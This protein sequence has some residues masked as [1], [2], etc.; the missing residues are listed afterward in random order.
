M[1]KTL[2]YISLGLAL[3]LVVGVLVGSKLVMQKLNNQPVSLSELPSPMAD[4]PECAKLV[5]S[6][7]GELA[8]HR[9][10]ELLDP[11][12]AGAAV[13]QSASDERVTLRCGVEAPLQYTEL[14][15]TIETGGARWIEITDPAAGADLS[16]W[17]TVD[18]SPVVAVTADHKAVQEGGSPVDKL[19]LSALPEDALEP[20]PAPL[21]ALEPA[22]G[23]TSVCEPLLSAL[24]D[25]LIPGYSRLDL[26]HVVSLDD[27]SAA[28]WG[29]D[30]VEPIVIRCGLAAPASYE[31]GAQLTQINDTPWFQEENSDGPATLLYALGRST[32]IAVS[33]PLGVGEE[34]LT[35]LTNLIEENVPAQ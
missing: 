18:R 11:A 20:A 14:T 2:I 6:L 28:A 21:S 34:A 9:R 15:P 33:L 30:N 26:N 25:E 7:P 1:N 4:S 3:A 12:P 5:E 8:G 17:F 10:A 31:P 32:D 13:W 22:D 35:K 29:G 24:P 16:T 19:D 27:A 23:A